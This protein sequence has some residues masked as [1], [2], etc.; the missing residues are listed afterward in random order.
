VLDRLETLSN[1]FQ[2]LS[3]SE[4]K[5]LNIKARLEMLKDRVGYEETVIKNV[6]SNAPV[7]KVQPK[8][9]ISDIRNKLKPKVSTV[10]QEMQ[11]V[12]EELDRALRKA[13]A[14]N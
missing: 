3:D 4:T 5:C 7:T 6:V 13:L 10:E 11:Q 2:F 8:E 1:E 12:D 9:D 14:E